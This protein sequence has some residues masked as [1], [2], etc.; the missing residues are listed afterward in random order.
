MNGEAYREAEVPAERWSEA[1][2]QHH[3]QL[4]KWGTIARQK[5][6]APAEGVGKAERAADKRR[7][8]DESGTT[9]TTM[10]Q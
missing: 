1:T 4:N 2:G 6:E 9:T 5:M 7:Q 8:R 10:I 3:N